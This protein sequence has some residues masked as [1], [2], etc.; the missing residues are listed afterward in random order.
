[1]LPAPSATVLPKTSPLIVTGPPGV[2]PEP[3]TVIGWLLTKHVPGT[4][5]VAA[6]AAAGAASA[7]AVTAARTAAERTCMFG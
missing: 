5:T 7:V 6:W 2:K 4:E 3:V 1:M